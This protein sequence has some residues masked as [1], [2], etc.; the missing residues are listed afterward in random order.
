MQNTCQ[1]P[2]TENI[3]LYQAELLSDLSLNPKTVKANKKCN[4][5]LFS[6]I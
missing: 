1:V 3:G 2:G 6:V 5:N 4:K